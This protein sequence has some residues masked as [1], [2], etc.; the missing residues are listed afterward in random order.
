MNA[1]SSK[2]DGQNFTVLGFPCNQFN[3]QEPGA[4]GTEIL[5][6]ITHV[7]PGFG[8][9]PK[10][11]IFEKIDV[12]GINE[13]KLFT[14]LKRNCPPTVVAFDTTLLFY[15]PIKASD[16]QWN[17]ETFLIG[18]NGRVIGRAAPSTDPQSL[19]ADIDI[20][21]GKATSSPVIVG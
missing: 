3:K 12:N 10:F 1:L 16:V 19:S 20:A 17:W 14:Y 21:L 6:G 5:N 9:V 7:R 15:S 13:H 18:A 4:N 8:F 2:Y 11:P